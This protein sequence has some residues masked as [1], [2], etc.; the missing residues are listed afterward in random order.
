MGTPKGLLNYHGRPWLEEQIARHAAAGGREVIVVLGPDVARYETE[1]LWIQESRSSRALLHQK[2]TVKT[3]LNLHPESGSFSSLLIGF[4]A[5]P[6]L[7]KGSVP[8]LVLPIDT[9]Y[10]TRVTIEAL[11]AAP[12]ELWAVIPQFEAQSG[13]PV[14][15]REEFIAYLS[16][17]DPHSAQARL[18][19]QLKMLESRLVQKVLCSDRCITLNLNHQDEWQRYC[20][21][22]ERG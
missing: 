5:L 17:L 3:I 19:M 8:C 14:L 9:P 6:P 13:H 15:L 22:F 11:H 12:G 4:S 10:P 16:H 18:D 20:R 7:K 1:I 2:V 21:E